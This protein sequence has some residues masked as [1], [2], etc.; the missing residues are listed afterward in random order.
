MPRLECAWVFLGSGSTAGIRLPQGSRTQTGDAA[1]D[2]AGRVS[3][4]P[5]RTDPED[6]NEETGLEQFSPKT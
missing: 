3:L 4:S 6:G 1:R 5:L 2:A